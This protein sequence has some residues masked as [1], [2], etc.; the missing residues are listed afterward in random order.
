[1]NINAGLRGPMSIIPISNRVELYKLL[2]TLNKFLKE[3]NINNYTLISDRLFKKYVT[4]EDAKIVEHIFDEIHHSFSSCLPEKEKVIFFKFR[5]S[6]SKLLEQLSFLYSK[7]ESNGVIKIIVSDLPYEIY[8]KYK[9][10][11]FYD[12]LSE[13]DEPYW[14]RNLFSEN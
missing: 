1:M 7:G 4:Y 13:D 11:D 9:G 14:M 8:D 6:F 12:N 10:N 5:A 2:K 3:N